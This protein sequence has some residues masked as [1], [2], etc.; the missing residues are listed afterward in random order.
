M[1][2]VESRKRDVFLV[3]FVFER[4]AKKQDAHNL[5]CNAQSLSYGRYI[6]PVEPW[7]RSNV[8]VMING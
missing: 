2:G 4:R 6:W 7:T 5:V 3:N 8:P 1:K